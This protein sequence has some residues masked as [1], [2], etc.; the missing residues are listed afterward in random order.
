MICVSIGRSR[1]KMMIAEHK[2]MAE[3]GVQ[4]AELRLDFLSRTPDTGPLLNDRP[5]PVVVTCRRAVDRGL[6]RGSEE[7]RLTTLR[8]AILAGVE[9]VDLEGDIA[10][11]IR[12]YGKTKRIVSHH[13][14][15]ET[16]PNLE[17][18]HASL[19]TL[20]PDI[21]KIAT[22]AKSHEDNI[23]MLQLV[24]NSKVPTIGF[25]MGELGIVSRVLT[26]KYG[27]PFTYAAVS[28]DR[29]LAP[30]QLTFDEMRDIY[31][32]DAI[33]AET[34]VFG[35]VGD[36][37]GHSLSPRLHNAAFRRAN[38][39]NVYLPFRVAPTT[40]LS[41]FKTFEWLNVRGY[42]V[43]IPHKE[44]LLEATKNQDGPLT[45][46]GAA[47][48]LY[49]DAANEWRLANTDYDAA[50]E[51]L[52][53]GLKG[54][55]PDPEAADLAGKRV[56]ILG[57]G[58]VS[59]AIAMG[60]MKAGA[61]LT[62][63]NRHKV[64]GSTLAAKLGCQYVTWENRGV[65]FA[66]ILINCTAVGMQPNVDDT[67]FVENWL[68]EGMLVFDTVYTPERTLLIK[69]ARDR[70]CRTVTG[71]E[72]FIRQAAHQFKLFTGLEPSLEEFRETLRA[73]ISVA[74]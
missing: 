26:G 73:A 9:Y 24:A 16:P 64:R 13:D 28:N 62:I 50:L 59:K 40:L 23:R 30:G 34:G 1:H 31:N 65:Q 11:Q 58:G 38:L 29:T 8:A 25:C 60:L 68:R 36:P 42:S 74:K 71:V 49:R 66:D 17:Q 53:E 72:M 57:A 63:T 48:T 39:N 37:I 47:N 61:A 4:L 44:E 67:P 54:D 51:S 7:Q 21:V 14:F 18:I 52:K 27:A 32:Y 55:S 41:T 5:T 22:M 69:Q 12:R 2:A 15:E 6:W 20:D 3:R 45:E 70:G 35:V 43:T 19:C 10:G 56:L 33:N 46:I